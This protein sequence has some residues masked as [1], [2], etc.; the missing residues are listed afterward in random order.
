MSEESAIQS[1]Q[2]PA[3]ASMVNRMRSLLS[4]SCLLTLYVDPI[5]MGY[6]SRYTAPVFAA[7]LVYSLALDYSRARRWARIVAW[8]DVAW[9]YLIVLST[10]GT[11][12]FFYPFFFFGIL[13]A[14]FTFGLAAGARITIASTVLIA[15]TAAFASSDAELARVL[16]RSTFMLALGYMISHWGGMVVS[17]R[18]R[19]ELLHEVSQQSN[20][21]FGVD[22]TVASVLDK[23]CRFYGA[24]TCLLLLRDTDTNEWMLRT[25]TAAAPDHALHAKRLGAEAA[26]PLL[27]VRSGQVLLYQRPLWR[28]LRR[29]HEAHECQRI[30]RNWSRVDPGPAGRLAE[31][32][33]AISLIAVQVPLRQGEGW[34]MIASRRDHSQQDALFLLQIAG[35]AFPIIENIALLDRMASEAVLRERERIAR[36]I[37]DSTIQPYIGLRHGVSAMRK[38]AT[39]D[40]PLLPDLDAL[41]EMMGQ[42][43][44]DLRRYAQTF[45]SGEAPREPELLVALR[46]QASQVKQF[47]GIDITV[48]STGQLAVNDRLAAEVFQIVNEGMSN[49][50]KHTEARNGAVTLACVKGE[51]RV[52]IE[53]D[54]RSVTQPDFLPQSIAERA[55]A[56]GGSTRVHAGAGRRTAIEVVIPV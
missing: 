9:F 3:D 37:H 50:R 47:Y 14:A 23:T 51:L 11:S 26:E 40:N 7:F 15:S 34:L 55:F 33:D 49:I 10:G 30:T 4:A 19:L 29:G 21:R 32:L 31:L 38:R 28:W 35:Q 20:P 13:S 16:L 17:Q 46:R 41:L 54:C 39:P 6:T 1:W 52:R 56:L 22:H 2:D 18:R 48:D 25:A 27:C 12:S 24:D 42:V 53:N 44:V 8:A 45:R 5:A 36:D 43:I